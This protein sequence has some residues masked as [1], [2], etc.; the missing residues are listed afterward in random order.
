MLPVSLI[1]NMGSCEMR[2]VT[3]PA[4][5]SSGTSP[6]K[7][8][9]SRSDGGDSTQ[10]MHRDASVRSGS[11]KSAPSTCQSTAQRSSG[12]GRRHRKRS[13][14]GESSQRVPSTDSSCRLS[15]VLPHVSSAWHLCQPVPLSGSF[16]QVDWPASMM[17]INT[18]S[19]PGNGGWGFEY[20]MCV[21]RICN[22]SRGGD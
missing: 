2:R 13:Y 20:G 14:A 22:I 8:L 19:G 15:P 5:V 1:K 17:G 12:Q 4:S 9:I 21:R 10:E 6:K 16:S 11:D 7:K 18:I 3:P